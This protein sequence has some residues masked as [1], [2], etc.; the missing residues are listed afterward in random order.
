VTDKQSMMLLFADLT[1]MVT[2]ALVLENRDDA[3]MVL[4]RI[5]KNWREVFESR[6]ERDI[7]K[8]N[9]DIPFVDTSQ[10][11]DALRQSLQTTL[12][13]TE[14]MLRGMMEILTEGSLGGRI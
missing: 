1:A 9:G 14:V 8:A 6:L 13:E 2:L 12:N 11:E 7:R 3:S 5:F 4:E 10:E